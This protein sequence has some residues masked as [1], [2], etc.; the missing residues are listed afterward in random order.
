MT[1]NSDVSRI[2]GEL[3][4]ALV[5]ETEEHIREELET[6]HQE[7]FM[8]LNKTIESLREENKKLRKENDKKQELIN[9]HDDIEEEQ[10]RQLI[11]L[12]NQ[13]QKLVEENKK[14]MEEESVLKPPPRYLE[15]ACSVA[16]KN[17]EKHFD[18]EKGT[19]SIDQVRGHKAG[20]DAWYSADGMKKKKKQ[21]KKTTRNPTGYTL[22]SKK[23]KNTINTERER[24]NIL[25][26]PKGEEPLGFVSVQ[27][28]LWKGMTDEHKKK[29]NDEAKLIAMEENV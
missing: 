14:L 23:E 26:K 8:K 28:I 5:I 27:A 3:K 18:M 16:V 11:K 10:G 19:V 17:Y 6:E 9:M 1:S 15:T 29:Y 4:E 12:T 22:F 20:L 7:D 13:N 21:K 25:G 24:L 2:L